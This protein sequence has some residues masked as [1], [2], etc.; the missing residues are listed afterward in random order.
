[1][2]FMPPLT[3]ALQEINL[4]IASTI[5]PNSGIADVDLDVLANR[6]SDAAGQ[7]WTWKTDLEF[8]RRGYEAAGWGIHDWSE[9]AVTPSLR[10]FAK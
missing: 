9:D 6:V 3:R 2:Q 5:N 1:M 10:F 4:M 8:L 7:K